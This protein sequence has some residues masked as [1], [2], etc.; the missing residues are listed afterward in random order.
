MGEKEQPALPEGTERT[1]ETEDRADKAVFA[2]CAFRRTDE[3]RSLVG[4]SQH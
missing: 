1:G 2:A 3:T 4:C